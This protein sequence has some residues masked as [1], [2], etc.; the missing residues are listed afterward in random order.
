MRIINT[1]PHPITFLFPDGHEETIQPC[2]FLLNARAEEREVYAYRPTHQGEEFR[3]AVVETRFIPTREGEAWREKIENEIDE[4]K[5]C[6]FIVGS[7][8]AA[9]AY[10]GIFAMIA[11]PGYERVPPDQKKMRADKFT[12]FR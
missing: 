9:Q 6:T 12:V 3:L 7:I 2:G 1:T 11:A 5:E 8:I 10:P 4:G